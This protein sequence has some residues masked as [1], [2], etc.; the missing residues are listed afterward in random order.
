MHSSIKLA[1]MVAATITMTACGGLK[2]KNSSPEGKK[3]APAEKVE[4]VATAEVTANKE[5]D[6]LTVRL[7]NSDKSALTTYTVR[8]SDVKPG[9]AIFVSMTGATDSIY[10]L[11]F[12]STLGTVNQAYVVAEFTDR[13]Y[14]SGK[15]YIFG[16]DGKGSLVLSAV[17]DLDKEHSATEL[18]NKIIAKAKETNE[19]I[20]KVV[21]AKNWNLP[22]QSYPYL[23]VD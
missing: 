16:N 19:S 7:P 13:T 8:S 14:K 22:Q 15:A 3:A 6:L 1:A 4:V 9:D 2:S 23:G 11:G 5:F 21:E 20:A 10:P 18:A 17:E 12:V